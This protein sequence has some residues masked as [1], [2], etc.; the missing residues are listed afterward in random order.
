MTTGLDQKNGKKRNTSWKNGIQKRRTFPRK[1]TM[2]RVGKKARAAFKVKIHLIEKRGKGDLEG[3][4]EASR[5]DWSFRP[6]ENEEIFTSIGK[7]RKVRTKK[8]RLRKSA[9]GKR[10]AVTG[11]PSKRHEVSQERS[12]RIRVSAGE[13]HQR[14]QQRPEKG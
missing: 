13:K 2:T 5:R 3:K 10:H 7:S 4:S 12:R 14:S 9:R 8:K 6:V 1:D 11:K